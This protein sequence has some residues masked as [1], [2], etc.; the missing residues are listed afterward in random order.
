MKYLNSLLFLLLAL[1]F[2]SDAGANLTAEQIA[3]LPRNAKFANR[4]LEGF[5]VEDYVPN[6]YNC[7]YGAIVLGREANYT[8]LAFNAAREN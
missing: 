2:P 5:A 3:E 4:F 6:T 8:H 7:L 1:L